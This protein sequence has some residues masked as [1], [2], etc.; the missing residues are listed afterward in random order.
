[1]IGTSSFRTVLFLGLA[2]LASAAGE[3]L[4][5]PGAASQY[6]GKG[7][8]KYS[9]CPASDFRGR[10]DE[11]IPGILSATACAE[12]CDKNAAC[13]RAVYDNTGKFC[14]IKGEEADTL[15]TQDASRRYTAIYFDNELPEAT[16]ISIC[17]YDDTTYITRT[18]TSYRTCVNTDFI[19][20]SVRM[21]EKVASTEACRA[22]CMENSA[23][24][25]AR[26]V[27]DKVDRVCHMKADA[28]SE[29]LV[30]YTDKRFD[31]IRQ[32]VVRNRAIEGS[33]SEIIRFPVIPVAAYIVPEFPTS[34]RMLVFSSWGNKAF[35]P[36]A[37]Y[38]QFTD[39]NFV[40]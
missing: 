23:T 33:W 30:W 37:G 21:I 26:A 16:V 12:L 1:M 6:T 28:V 32:E 20:P 5:C 22:L 17:P 29:T 15:L 7:G 40:T 2:T 38:T 4:K 34:S 14:H 24:G 31:V 35:G 8:A 25:C 39:Y 13:L 36:A 10:S 3:S 18:G 19:G 27:Y 11:I 9:V